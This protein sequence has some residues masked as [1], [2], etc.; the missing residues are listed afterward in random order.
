MNP[1]LA[2]SSQSRLESS[3]NRHWLGWTMR[4]FGLK[5]VRTRFELADLS[6]F[7]RHLHLNKTHGI[8]MKK[9]SN[10]GLSR[11][12]TSTSGSVKSG[13]SGGRRDE[14]RVGDDQVLHGVVLLNHL[15]KENIMIGSWDDIDYSSTIIISNHERKTSLMSS[16]S[17]VWMLMLITGPLP[18]Q[19]CSLPLALL[20]WDLAIVSIGPLV[21]IV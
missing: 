11:T 9:N 19:R 14:L 4:A 16:S 21:E 3:S 12:S 10:D 1:K 17:P 6:S 8:S 7:T 15:V 5:L 18:C 20:G 13:A 2:K